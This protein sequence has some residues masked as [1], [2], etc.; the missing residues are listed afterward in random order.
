M[1]PFITYS[2]R[3]SLHK[4]R[5]IHITFNFLLF[6]GYFSP[7]WFFQYIFFLFLTWSDEP[8]FSILLHHD[9]NFVIKIYTYIHRN[10]HSIDWRTQN[11]TKKKHFASAGVILSVKQWGCRRKAEESRFNFRQDEEINLFTK[12]SRLSVVYIQTFA[13]WVPGIV[14]WR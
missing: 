6:V 2:R 10:L 4:L 3:Q 14:S 13:Q 11:K 1:F 8:I 9:I 7:P 12:T 5:P